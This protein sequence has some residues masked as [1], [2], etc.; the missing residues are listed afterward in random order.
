MLAMRGKQHNPQM[1]DFCCILQLQAGAKSMRRLFTNSVEGE[2]SEVRSIVTLRS[3]RA[4]VDRAFRQQGLI[5]EQPSGVNC[6]SVGGLKA[7][8]T[9]TERS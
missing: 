2:F 8:P 5:A 9:K 4:A 6:K 1:S 3:R 7:K